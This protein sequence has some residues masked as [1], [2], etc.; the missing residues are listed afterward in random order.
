MAAVLDKFIRLIYEHDLSPEDIEEVILAP[1][2]TEK[3]ELCSENRLIS[4]E[5][6]A[7]YNPYLASCAAHRL[8]FGE[9]QDEETKKNPEIK[10]F[11]NK[12][13]VLPPQQD[14]LRSE[15][16]GDIHAHGM[17]V[18]IMARGKKISSETSCDLGGLSCS[19]VDWS[20]YPDEIRAT[21]Q[22]LIEKFEDLVSVSILSDKITRT[23]SL[24]LELEDVSD[25]EY[26]MSLLQAS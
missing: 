5:D 23:T 12:V 24:L 15:I 13:K 7:F 1:H 3:N 17:G 10:N 4:E 6:Y 16:T 22:D 8:K 26:I 9:Y 2:A 21:D 11:M 18:E 20:W 25:F 14:D 19:Y